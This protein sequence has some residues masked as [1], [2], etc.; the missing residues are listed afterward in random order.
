MVHQEKTYKMLLISLQKILIV[1]HRALVDEALPCANQIDSR[2]LW[3]K[4]NSEKQIIYL[5][6]T[7][8]DTHSLKKKSVTILLSCRCGETSNLLLICAA[9]H[10]PPLIFLLAVIS[11]S[12]T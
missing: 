5:Q 9:Y 6:V 3:D 10:Q 4:S 2:I 7:V 11:S 12:K 1:G 8:R